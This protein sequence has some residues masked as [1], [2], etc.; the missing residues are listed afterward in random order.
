MRLSF[1]I[2]VCSYLYLTSYFFS[3]S[4]YNTLWSGLQTTRR[5]SSTNKHYKVIWITTLIRQ[6]MQLETIDEQQI[7]INEVCAMNA[8]S[9]PQAIMPVITLASPQSGSRGPK[10][11]A[12]TSRAPG[13]SGRTSQAPG[14][15]GRTSPE[16]GPSGRP[17]PAPGPFIVSKKPKKK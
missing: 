6:Y 13:P 8:G 1:M 15:S 12:S 16:P 14:P 2:V 9:K 17:T 11:S 10:P 4:V 3:A 5:E 7:F